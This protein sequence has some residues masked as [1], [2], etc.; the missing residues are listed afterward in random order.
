MERLLGM[1]SCLQIRL[2]GEPIAS[3]GYGFRG[4]IS[5]LRPPTLPRLRQGRDAQ[6]GDSRG[7]IGDPE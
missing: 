6:T 4:P 3:G 1:R 7:A 5:S 2:G